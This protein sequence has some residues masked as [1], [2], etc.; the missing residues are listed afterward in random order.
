MS[1]TRANIATMRRDWFADLTGFRESRYEETRRQLRIEDDELVSTVNGKRYNIGSL[2]LPA[3]ADLRARVKVPMDER[4]T[5]R[6]VT[7]DA[8]AMHSDPEYDGAMFQVASQF[9]L[10][11]MT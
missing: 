7:G 5:V 8:R 2:S 10:L 4:T 11:E 6:C 1:V 9:N 3:L